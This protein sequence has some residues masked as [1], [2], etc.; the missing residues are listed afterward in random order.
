MDYFFIYVCHIS[1]IFSGYYY[2]KN[3]SVARVSLSNVEDIDKT[4]F[5][6]SI[7]TVNSGVVYYNIDKCNLFINNYDT[8]LL[9]DEESININRFLIFDFKLNRFSVFDDDDFEIIN[10][11]LEENIKI[12][13]DL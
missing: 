11:R 2:D 9:G 10:K 7:V 5:I 6:K 13:D 8:L 3:G 4:S 1:D 12:I